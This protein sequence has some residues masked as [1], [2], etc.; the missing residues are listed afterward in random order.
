VS[1]AEDFCV[2]PCAP[3][4]NKT[5]P[6]VICLR[7]II[8]YSSISEMCVPLSLDTI[9]NHKLLL[10]LHIPLQDVAGVPCVRASKSLSLSVRLHARLSAVCC[11]LTMETPFTRRCDKRFFRF[12]PSFS[13]HARVCFGLPK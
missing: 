8:L 4:E 6:H 9:S 1:H 10:Y 3:A 13:P 11:I 5:A 2:L 12:C 7:V